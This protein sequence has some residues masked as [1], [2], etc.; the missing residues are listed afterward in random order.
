M[1]ILYI[2]FIHTIHAGIFDD[3][4]NWF[5]SGSSTSTQQPRRLARKPPVYVSKSKTL[6][7]VPI[8][9]SLPDSTPKVS[10]ISKKRRMIS[11]LEIIFKVPSAEKD[12]IESLSADVPPLNPTESPTSFDITS[13]LIKQQHN[14]DQDKSSKEKEPKKMIPDKFHTDIALLRSSA[15]RGEFSAKFL[16][17]LMKSNWITSSESLEVMLELCKH[18]PNR[19]H[20]MIPTLMKLQP[21]LFTPKDVFQLASKLVIQ[22]ES[23]T[24][25]EWFKIIQLIPDDSEYLP[26]LLSLLHTQ[27]KFGSKDWVLILETLKTRKGLISSHLYL[28]IF[29]E[30]IKSEIPIYSW[31]RL[32]RLLPDDKKSL[33]RFSSSALQYNSY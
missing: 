24:F 32:I 26:K 14:S 30:Q 5:N 15:S 8:A 7:S 10:S 25:K 18:A 1:L 11:I 2:L 20:G 29:I 4:K 16:S 6:D 9:S 17:Y 33:M 22:K 19:I 23:L 31:Q 27:N 13:I 28:S 21:E 3:V 12:F